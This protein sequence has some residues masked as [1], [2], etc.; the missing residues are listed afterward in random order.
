MHF[1][2]AAFKKQ[3]VNIHLVSACVCQVNNTFRDNINWPAY[4]GAAI[5]VKTGEI[6]AAKFP[7]HQREPEIS[8]RSTRLYTGQSEMI[9][10]YDNQSE[11]V[12]IG[13]FNYEPLRGVDLWLKQPDDVILQH[14]S[15]SPQ[16]EPPHFVSQLKLTLSYIQKNPFPSIT[17]FRNNRPYYYR[18]TSRG[19]WE[20]VMFSNEFS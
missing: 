18:L 2:A 13:P 12:K 11:M 4:T 3:A 15:T 5:S 17:L 10:I 8:L 20:H 6:F 9:E 7:Y 19:I 14:L 16:V 1:L